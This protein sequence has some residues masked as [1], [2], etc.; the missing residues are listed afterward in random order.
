MQK[1]VYFSCDLRVH[2][3]R[4][5]RE[6]SRITEKRLRR[7]F[8]KSRKRRKLAVTYFWLTM[9]RGHP[10]FIVLLGDHLLVNTSIGATSGMRLNLSTWYVTPVQ[11]RG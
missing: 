4:R 2:R 7:L 11:K 1:C 10:H 8:Y 5:D 9:Y 3:H 6:P